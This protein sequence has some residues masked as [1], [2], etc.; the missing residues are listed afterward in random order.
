MGDDEKSNESGVC[1]N[2]VGMSLGT[3][4]KLSMNNLRTKKGRTI[5]TAV[6]GSIGIVGIALILSLSTA[7]NDYMD[8]Y[9]AEGYIKFLSS[10]DS[11]TDC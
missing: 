3:A 10:Y 11:V 1:T 4:F 2:K 8:G 6:A 5:L 7:V 9:I